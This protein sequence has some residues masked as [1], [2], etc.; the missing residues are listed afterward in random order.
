[1]EGGI[2]Q[3]KNKQWVKTRVIKWV[4]DV[5]KYIT[6]PVLRVCSAVRYRKVR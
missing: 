6:M 1:M 2:K 3:L 4:G 5:D